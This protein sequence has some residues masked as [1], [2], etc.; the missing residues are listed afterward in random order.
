[1][2]ADGRS[3]TVSF[4]TASLSAKPSVSTLDFTLST[5]GS[6]PVSGLMSIAHNPLSPRAPPYQALQHYYPL[7]DPPFQGS[8][9]RPSPQEGKKGEAQSGCPLKN[10]SS[11][12]ALPSLMFNRTIDRNCSKVP[13]PFAPRRRWPAVRRRKLNAVF[14][15]FSNGLPGALFLTCV[16]VSLTSSWLI[17][18]ILKVLPGWRNGRRSGLKIHRGQPRGSSS[19]PPG[20]RIKERQGAFSFQER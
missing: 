17:D 13:A 2:A 18:R 7:I 16:W 11:S 12:T 3:R 19:L 20:T 14:A 10:F 4:N 15:V 6:F 5:A 9:P 1:M 8:C